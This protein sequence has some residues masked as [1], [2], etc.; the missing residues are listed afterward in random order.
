MEMNFC[1]RC[2][3]PLTANTATEY[4]CANHHRIYANPDSS[5]NIFFLTDDDHVMMSIRGIEP[6]KGTLDTF[7]GFIDMGETAEQ[8]LVREI[9]EETGLDENQYSSPTFLS[10]GLFDY[11][12]EGEPRETL[13]LFYWSRL[14]PGAVLTAADDVAEVTKV[15][16]FD[17]ND[18]ILEGMK[19]SGQFLQLRSLIASDKSL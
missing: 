9:R 3:A 5:V 4:V 10:T 7:G 19:V 2:G 16:L 14:A 13:S 15:P 18:S 17:T 1:R 8:A 11:P 6:F 12:F